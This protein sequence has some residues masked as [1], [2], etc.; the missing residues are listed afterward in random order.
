MV[1]CM[2]CATGMFLEAGVDHWEKVNQVNYMGV[3]YTLKA[4][5]PSLVARNSGRIVV[6]NSSG[7]F[8]GTDIDPTG[9]SCFNCSCGRS[10]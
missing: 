7:G 4:V 10:R 3:V 6:T 8:M 9:S 1:P 2:P 5:L